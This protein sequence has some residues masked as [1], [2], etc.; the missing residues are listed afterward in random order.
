MSVFKV[1]KPGILLH[2]KHAFMPNS[3]GYCG[4]D[5]RGAILSHLQGTAAS[6]KLLKVLKSF[7]AA[8]PFVK[9]IGKSTGRQPFDYRV[10]EAYWI[11]NELL[12]LVPPADFYT[13]SHNTLQ[14]RR[15]SEV[16][17]VFKTLGTGVR[18]HHTFHVMS[19]YATSSVLD[20]P[21]L[22]SDSAKKIG[23]L[24]DSCRI[25]W[26]RVTRVGK[27]ELTVSYKPVMLEEREF[28]LAEPITKKVR[29]E[30]EVKP[31]ETV[32]IGDWVSLHWN[33]ACEVL[34]PAQVRNL[35]KFTAADIVSTNDLLKQLHP[36][37]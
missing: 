22:N 30:K 26:G 9:L 3:L 25:S 8:Y 1:Q 14:K 15:R 17:K 5:D 4:P 31:F 24:V 23:A 29:Y 16:K 36:G 18:P 6:P 20:G 10:S 12:G 2:A 7:E 19:T 28:S 35:S 27:K 32:K 11:G 37:R 13:F 33:F 34:R 21:N